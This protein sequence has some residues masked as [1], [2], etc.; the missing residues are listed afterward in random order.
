MDQVSVL[1]QQLRPHI[2]WHGARLHFLCLF[3]LALLKVRTVNR[4]EL[5]LAFGG[6]AQPASSYKRLQRFFRQF[7]W[8]ESSLTEMLLSILNI[9]EPW[10]LSIDRTNWKLG[11]TNINILML[12]VVYQG[13]AIPLLWHLVDK[14]GNSNTEERIDLLEKFLEQ[15]GDHQIDYIVA[16][17]EFIGEDWFLYLLKYTSY[18]FCIRL[19]DNTK[20]GRGK[21]V[22]SAKVLFAHLKVGQTQVLKNRRLIWGHYLYVSA[23]RFPDRSFLLLATPSKPK[24]ALK[25]YANRWP[26]ETLFG[27]FKSRGFRLEETHMTDPQRL[28]KLLS[29]LALALCWCLK[30]G[31]VQWGY[32]PLKPKKHGRLPKSLFRYGYD[33]L[34]QVCLNIDSQWQEYCKAVRLLTPSPQKIGGT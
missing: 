34:R 23:T 33:H 2:H 13:V 24:S 3:L 14:Q 7:E 21:T 28:S 9:P 25:D 15:L 16:D 12:G 11:K 18:R 1:K 6:T 27:I 5:S 10:G 4:P 20:I 31:E 26:I 19:K 22:S 17:R 8:D 32:H 30:S 29:L